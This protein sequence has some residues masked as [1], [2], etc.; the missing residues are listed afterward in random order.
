ML[1]PRRETISLSQPLRAARLVGGGPAPAVA[2]GAAHA[3]AE[4]ERGRREGEKSLSEQLLRQRGELI[5]L[6]NGVLHSLQQAVTQVTR[7]CEGAMIALALEIA[8]KLVGDLPISSEMV[9]AS[10]REALAHVEQGSQLTVLLNP[11][12]Y[13]LLQQAN[14]PV[15]LTDVGGERL[16]FQ[17]SPQVT[18]GGC[19]VQTHFGVIDAR[20]ETKL[21]ALQQSLTTSCQ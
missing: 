1:M 20:R 4:Y 2:A 12:D 6:Q 10:V 18:R 3:R 15:L 16:K 14:A 9:E 17:T 13:E 21:A 5:E 11:M 7:E 8:G 19:M